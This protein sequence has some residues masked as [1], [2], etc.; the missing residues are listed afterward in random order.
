MTSLCSICHSKPSEVS[1]PCLSPAPVFCAGCYTDHCNASEGPHSA[2]ALDRHPLSPR[3]ESKYQMLERYSAA[4]KELEQLTKTQVR[5][6]QR[7]AGELESESERKSEAILVKELDVACE[8]LGRGLSTAY[9]AAAS[10]IELMGIADVPMKIR[11]DLAESTEKIIRMEEE[12]NR[13]KRDLQAKLGMGEE[14]KASV[15]TLR[16]DCAEL[17]EANAKLI[18]RLGRV[19]NEC[20]KL[21]GERDR[22]QERMRALNQKTQYLEHEHDQ[23]DRREPAKDFATADA[24]QTVCPTCQI[25]TW[26]SNDPWRVAAMSKTPELATF[27]SDFCSET[28]YERFRKELGY[29]SWLSSLLGS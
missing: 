27:M 18:V 6:A 21:R 25:N 5:Q 11:Q 3:L 14:E 2:K 24:A 8:V 13:L 9:Q 16:K 4:L 20:G 1:C 28:C 7:L 10:A 23:R 17:K 29:G 19:E 15:E 22:A 12:R 26:P